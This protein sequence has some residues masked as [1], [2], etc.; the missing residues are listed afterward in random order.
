MHLR[1]FNSDRRQSLVINPKITIIEL[2]VSSLTFTLFG[3]VSKSINYIFFYN[4]RYQ[5]N[6]VNKKIYVHK[7]MLLVFVL[8]TSLYIIFQSLRKPADK[9]KKKV[10]VTEKYLL[11]V[12][13]FLN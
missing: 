12:G 13:A 11:V 1:V 8:K 7:E 5:P 6:I 4:N 10:H 9:I 3:P 2:L